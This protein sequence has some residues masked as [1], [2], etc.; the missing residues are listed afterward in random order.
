MFK[1][2]RRVASDPTYFV[3]WD[4]EIRRHER[5]PVVGERR[6]TKDVK[7]EPVWL[8]DGRYH[9]MIVREATDCRTYGPNARLFRVGEVEGLEARSFSAKWPT[10]GYCEAYRVLEELPLAVAFGPR[11]DRAL[12]IVTR[13]E[14]LTPAEVGALAAILPRATAPV[15]DWNRLKEVGLDEASFSGR[16]RISWA[17]TMLAFTTSD[18]L[19]EMRDGCTLEPVVTD[20]GW[21]RV[22]DWAQG[23]ASAALV[24]QEDVERVWTEAVGVMAAEPTTQASFWP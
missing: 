22:L 21:C 4:P 2:Q 9:F 1:R 16:S 18:D 6:D 12:E 10:T 14:R 19:Y 13:T 7:P 20:P 5:C 15:T 17:L 23:A 24:G 8:I 11:G 3:H